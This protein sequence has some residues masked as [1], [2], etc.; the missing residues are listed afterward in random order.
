MS[1]AVQDNL[2]HWLPL[3]EFA[4]NNSVHASTGVTPFFTEKGFH[5]RIEATVRA[6]PADRFVPDMP[7]EKARAEKLVELQAAI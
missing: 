3:A 6:I 2:V 1:I 7:D 5:P 4:F